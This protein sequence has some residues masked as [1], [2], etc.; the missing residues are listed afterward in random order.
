MNP[1]RFAALLKIFLTIALVLIAGLVAY[2]YSRL[3]DVSSL[4]RENPG[5][6]AL[7][8]LRDQ[9]RRHSG[10]KPLRRHIWVPYAAISEHVKKAVL[11]GED[12]SFF[13]HQGVDA[14]ELKE[15]IK[16]DWERGRFKRGA[17]TVTMQLAKNLY[18]SPTKSPLRKLRE[19]AIAL[20]MERVLSKRRI[21][22][23]YLNVI[24]WGTGIYGVQ[25]ASQHY[26]SRAASDLNPLEAATLAALLPNPLHPREPTLRRRRNLILTRMFKRGLISQEE[27]DRVNREPLFRDRDESPGP[28]MRTG[29]STR[30][31]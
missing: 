22:E 9:E 5:T 21:F 30:L 27:F 13:S 12:A 11:L 1:G 8:Q 25:A 4:R 2:E 15:A 18:L 7:M 24:E 17:S 10:L 28:L 29:P 26:F 31:W 23:I 20:R 6:T 3:P 14:F 19:I 16:E